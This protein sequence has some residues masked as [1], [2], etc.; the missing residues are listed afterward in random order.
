[1][2][3]KTT[4][5]EIDLA[6]LEKLMGEMINL[7]NDSIDAKGIA[8]RSAPKAK[9]RTTRKGRPKH[10][11]YLQLKISLNG[12]KPLIWRRV[13]VDPTLSLEDMNEVIWGV[14][15]WDGSHMHSFS[16]KTISVTVPY[17]E[18]PF[19]DDT[20][21]YES[22]V[23]GDFFTEVGDKS[24]YEYDFGDSW[25][26]TILLEKIVEPLEK[27]RAKFITGKCMAP[28]EDCGGV[29]GYENLKE[30][31]Q[32]PTDPEY[33]E[34]RDWMGMDDDEVFDPK[35]LGFT[36]EDIAELNEEFEGM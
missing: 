15:P 6:T 36:A 7:Y 22:L 18:D 19:N 17:E 21:D 10:N 2:A 1:M 20:D 9:K 8:K 25:E 35:D 32:D 31:M 23:I 16:N 5:P 11:G 33:Q 27:R 24:Q 28:P 26:H 4:A 34:M 13:V 30:V 14:M 12:I 3:K 29:W